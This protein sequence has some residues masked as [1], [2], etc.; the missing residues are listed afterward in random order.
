MLVATLGVIGEPLEIFC[1]LDAAAAAAPADYC[2]MHSNCYTFVM[3]LCVRCQ[4]K[5]PCHRNRLMLVYTLSVISETEG[6]YL[7]IHY[8]G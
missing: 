4:D 1:A 2:R 8:Y 5:I 7:L 3:S 6:I